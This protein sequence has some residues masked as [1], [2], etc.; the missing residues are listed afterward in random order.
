M[1]NLPFS[2][3]PKR[4][5]LKGPSLSGHRRVWISPESPLCCWFP[6]RDT[7]HS[8]P[9]GPVAFPLHTK[10][11]CSQGINQHVVTAH[12]YW[13]T[14]NE[15]GKVFPAVAWK[16]LVGSYK[17]SPFLLVLPCSFKGS[18]SSLHS[19]T[20]F[21]W[22]QVS[23]LYWV[24]WIFHPVQ[25]PNGHLYLDICSKI[26]MLQASHSSF[27]PGSC[28]CHPCVNGQLYAKQYRV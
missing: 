5:L 4:Y 28:S 15:V 14:Q 16:H 3:P 22:F 18:W 19:S 21:P 9:Q 17:F 6:S 24:H 2:V 26:T 8:I 20:F 10:H 23:H 11:N 13:W 7:C 1:G 12:R 25:I 27:L